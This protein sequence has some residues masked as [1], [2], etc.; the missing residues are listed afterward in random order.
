MYSITINN[1]RKYYRRL[2]NIV[3]KNEMLTNK[4]N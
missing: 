2:S 4:K 1:K 3:K